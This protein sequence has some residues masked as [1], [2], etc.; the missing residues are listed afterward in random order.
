MVEDAVYFDNNRT[1]PCK[2]KT[3]SG[4][5]TARVTQIFE[6]KDASVVKATIRINRDLTVSKIV[7]YRC[8]LF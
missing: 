3:W 8:G 5:E 2:V 4:K 1:L 7:E 6:Q